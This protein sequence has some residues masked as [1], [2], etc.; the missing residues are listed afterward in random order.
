MMGGGQKRMM[1]GSERV[2]GWRG[3]ME[4]GK[5]SCEDAHFI[6]VEEGQ[7]RATDEA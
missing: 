4:G 1:G 6:G 2:M 7:G 5:H 3:E